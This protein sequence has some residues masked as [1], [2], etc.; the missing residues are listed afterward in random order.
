VIRKRFRNF[1]KFSPDDF[2]IIVRIFLRALVALGLLIVM[3]TAQR[4]RLPRETKRAQRKRGFHLE[5]TA[6]ALAFSL[7]PAFCF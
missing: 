3:V 4:R 2:E 5:R 1:H 7:S 6:A